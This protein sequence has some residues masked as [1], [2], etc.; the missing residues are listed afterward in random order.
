[1][2]TPIQLEIDDAEM[3]PNI[4]SAID[5][6]VAQLE[7]RFGKITSCRVTVRGNHH[8]TGGPN[9]VRIRL[10]IPDGREVNVTR[11]PDADERH[12]DLAFAVNDAFKR[13]RRQLEDQVNRLQGEVKLHTRPAAPG[14]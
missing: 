1:M 7:L 10:A 6:H 8:R 9:E 5:D 11:T 4:R 2:Q 3:A 14:D 13:A 12:G